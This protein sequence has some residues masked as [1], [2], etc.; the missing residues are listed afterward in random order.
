MLTIA[1]RLIS[2]GSFI[3]ISHR[4]YGNLQLKFTKHQA[5]DLRSDTTTQPTDAMFDIMKTASRADDVFAEDKSI[6][7]LERYVADL[8]GH[9]EAVF[10]VSGSMSNQL[11]LRLLLTQPPH[12]V[13]CDA[14]SHIY[15][16]ECGGMSYHS[17][18]SP[19]PILPR[20]GHHL[21]VEDM[22]NN[23][24]TDPLHSPTT[25][26]VSLENTLN[27]TI[28]PLDEIERIH[29]FCQSH[30]LKMHL[31]GARLWN[32]SQATGIPLKTYSQYFDTV[33]VCLSKGVGAPIGSVLVGSSST[34]ARARHLRKLMGGGWR[35]A[36]F[37]AAAAHHCIQNV[38]PTMP[39][40]HKLARRLAS[41]FEA[42]GIQITVPCETNMVFIDTS[43]VGIKI[44][45]L[46]DELFKQNVLIPKSSGY[47][48]RLVLHYQVPSNTVDTIIKVTSELIKKQQTN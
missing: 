44:D 15:N 16:Y 2:K 27:G 22:E 8:L 38:V 28:M 6:H 33:S 4:C 42:M 7:D 37:L 21:T 10:C 45:L 34:M 20:N 39:E 29:Q 47:Q 25:R 18:A 35:Q 5:I 3:P 19:S 36:G 30:D 11:G 31:D 24:M 32:A 23:L 1:T 9:E 43:A 13:I 40:T 46:A 26:V 12:S 41:S 17:Q 48:T 14:R